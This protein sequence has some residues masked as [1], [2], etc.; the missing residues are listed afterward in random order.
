M[1]Q[2]KRAIIMAAGIGRRMQPLT[3]STPKPLV[4]VGGRRI[5]ETVIDGLRTNGI[6]RFM[7]LWDI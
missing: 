6:L 5:I 7:W 4:R 1:Q 3:F 2:V